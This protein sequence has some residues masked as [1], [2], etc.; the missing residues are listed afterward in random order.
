MAAGSNAARRGRISRFAPL[1]FC[2]V[3]ILILS[4]SGASMENTS[5]FLLPLLQIL[6]PAADD[7]VLYHYVFLLRKFAHLAEYALLAL[8]AARAFLPSSK[9]HLS[10]WWHGAAI[11]VVVVV[12]AADEVIQSF[13]PLR[14]GTFSD[15]ALDIAG[16]AIGILTFIALVR[17]ASYFHSPARNPV[18]TGSDGEPAAAERFVNM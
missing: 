9:T 14:S 11:M 8:L 7:V 13:N 6:F 4:G 2:I 5:R 12:S 15:V 10:R 17:I 18:D 3:V 1:L 16:G